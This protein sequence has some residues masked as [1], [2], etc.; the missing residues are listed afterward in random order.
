MNTELEE[1]FIE[2]RFYYF[3]QKLFKVFNYDVNIIDIIHAYCNVASIPVST[4]NRLIK[5]IRSKESNLAYTPHEV[6]Y[7]A[8]KLNISYRETVRYTGVSI[9]VQQRKQAF[10]DEH[11]DYFNNLTRHSSELDY[12]EIEKF[13]TILDVMRRI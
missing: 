3:I 10:V 7:I 6:V 9:S 13:V 1:R 8:R 5:D 11:P 12:K 2:I 4:I